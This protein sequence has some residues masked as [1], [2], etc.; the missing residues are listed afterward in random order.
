MSI[1]HDDLSIA[2]TTHKTFPSFEMI[3]FVGGNTSVAGFVSSTLKYKAQTINQ[4]EIWMCSLL[5]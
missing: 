1:L 2:G 3:A 4:I 5:L